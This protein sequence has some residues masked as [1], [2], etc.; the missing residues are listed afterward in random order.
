MSNEY[1]GTVEE[2][3]MMVRFGRG[4]GGAQCV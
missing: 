2:G 3:V 1:R 4:I